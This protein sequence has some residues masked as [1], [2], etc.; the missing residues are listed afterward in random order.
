MHVGGIGL[1]VEAVA[2][3]F[4]LS[5]QVGKVVNLPVAD[6]PDSA[7]LVV[8]GLFA[9]LQINDGEPTHCEADIALQVK[10]VIIGA[11]VHESFT[12]G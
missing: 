6:Y 1:G 9:G 3:G 11:A 2:F 7:V 4:Q 10:P 5:P 12:H 8:D